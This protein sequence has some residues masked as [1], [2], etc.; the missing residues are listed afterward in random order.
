MLGLGLLLCVWS[1]IIVSL[2]VARVHEEAEV[3]QRRLDR[4]DRE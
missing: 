4:G 1:V 3:D 2:V